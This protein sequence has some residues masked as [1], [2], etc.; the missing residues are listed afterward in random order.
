[1][2]SVVASQDSGELAGQRE[3]HTMNRDTTDTYGNPVPDISVDIGSRA[4]QTAEFPNST[5]RAQ[6]YL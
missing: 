3:N 2:W 4:L 1:M 6:S 5:E